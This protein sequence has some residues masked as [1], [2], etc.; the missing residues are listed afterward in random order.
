LF[1]Q[2]FPTSDY[3]LWAIFADKFT[4]GYPAHNAIQEIAQEWG[5]GPVLVK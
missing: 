2:T 1:L 5:G 3:A 4:S